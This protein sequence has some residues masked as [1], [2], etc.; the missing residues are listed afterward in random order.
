[1]TEFR[2]EGYGKGHGWTKKNKKD[3]FKFVQSAK[4]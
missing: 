2:T 3:A 1:M 4:R